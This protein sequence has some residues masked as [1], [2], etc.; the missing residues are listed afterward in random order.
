VPYSELD[1]IRK[2]IQYQDGMPENFGNAQGKTIPFIL[3]D[4]LKQ[5]YSEA[6]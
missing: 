2:N 3:D 4:F 6:V 1:K 5:V